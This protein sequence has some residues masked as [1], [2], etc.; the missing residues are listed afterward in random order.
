MRIILD[1][2]NAW[3]SS[4]KQMLGSDIQKW[5][6]LRSDK[7]VIKKHPLAVYN[8]SCSSVLERFEKTVDEL[9]FVSHNISFRDDWAGKLLESQHQL[10][11]SIMEY[12]DDCKGILDSFSPSKKV[13][14]SYNKAIEEYRDH[15]GKIANNIKHSQGRLRSIAFFNNEMI[16]PGY[17]VANAVAENTLGPEKN[18]HLGNT[19]FSFARD[20]RYHLFHF[21]YVGEKLGETISSIVGSGVAPIPLHAD[22]P[23]TRLVKIATIISELPLFYYP[24]EIAKPIPS[25]VVDHDTSGEII[26]LTYPDKSVAVLDLP[27]P[28]KVVVSY[29]GDGVTTT[30]KIPYGTNTG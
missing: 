27:K 1:C 8:T 10:L 19:V 6:N 16:L 4:V 20:L 30:F 21:F 11:Y 29:I 7:D 9:T 25:V 17:F 5:L 18:I 28:M 22:A 24:D 14:N 2:K 15:I 26:I 12:L 3:S 13:K 23:D